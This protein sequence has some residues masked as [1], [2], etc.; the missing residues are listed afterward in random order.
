MRRLWI[1]LTIPWLFSAQSATVLLA[2]DPGSALHFDGIDDI[3]VIP[4]SDELSLSNTSPWTVELWFMRTSTP[5]IYHILG[6]RVG[7]VSGN[8]NYQLAR[9]PGAFAFADP[10]CNVLLPEPPENTWTH[11]AVTH[12]GT[13]LRAYLYGHLLRQSACDLTDENLASL[14]LGN[15]GTCP[16]RFPGFIDELRFWNVARSAD[17]ILNN[18]NCTV[19]PSTPGLVGYWKFD[20]AIDT[21]I[22]LDSSPSQNHG[23]RGSTIGIEGN[24]PLREV[25]SVPL[26]CSLVDVGGE[27]NPHGG[28]ARLLRLGA[29]RPNPM[30]SSTE[31][32][33]SVLKEAPVTISVYDITGSRVR[34]LVDGPQA[35]GVHRTSWD[36]RDE[37]GRTVASGLYFVVARCAGESERRTIAVIR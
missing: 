21:Q 33:F 36:A 8:F 34:V 20:E 17:D 29:P 18:F 19:D 15:S 26:A 13:N 16:Q 35:A 9:D 12:D 2:D 10:A 7:C 24:D 30:S 5:T 37:S 23:I 6:K 22:I 14:I 25:S 27:P 3:A 1:L 28:L 32:G 11:L 4:H 31:I